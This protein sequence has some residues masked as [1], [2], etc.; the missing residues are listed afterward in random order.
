MHPRWRL[1]PPVEAPGAWQMA[2]DEWLL[3]RHSR[4]L[5]PPV[6]RFYTWWPVAVSLGYHQR[7]VPATWEELIW[8][9]EVVELVRRPTGGRA[10]LHQGDL[11]YAVVTSGLGGHRLQSYQAI[12]QFLIKGWRRLGVELDYGIAKRSE[13]ENPSCFATATEADLVLP[14]GAKLIGS[15]QVLRRG[16][17]LQHGSMRLWPDRELLRQIFGIEEE[18]PTLPPSLPQEPEALMSLVTE[19]LIAAAEECFNAQF[20]VEPF[21][22][23]EVAEIDAFAACRL[24]R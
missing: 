24:R 12:C 22:E 5:H 23:A 17:I 16:A 2:A 14:G 6:L 13:G 3:E 9:G 15:A 20:M 1:I 7:R 4:R 8:G 10:V 11:T 18:L 19:A 21:S